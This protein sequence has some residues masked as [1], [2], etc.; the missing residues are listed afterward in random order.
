MLIAHATLKSVSNNGVWRHLPSHTECHQYTLKTSHCVTLKMARPDNEMSANKIS[1]IGWKH[2]TW[3]LIT[4]SGKHAMMLHR[5]HLLHRC[6][7]LEMPLPK[8]IQDKVKDQLD[9]CCHEQRLRQNCSIYI[10][11][12]MYFVNLIWYW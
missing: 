6:I 10:H 4:S 8:N 5:L 9:P 1:N 3:I 12:Y 2:P 7:A 11:F